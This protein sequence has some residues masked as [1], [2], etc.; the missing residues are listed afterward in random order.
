MVTLLVQLFDIYYN[1]EAN[2]QFEG[3]SKRVQ[4]AWYSKD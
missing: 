3:F 4:A 1:N 2:T